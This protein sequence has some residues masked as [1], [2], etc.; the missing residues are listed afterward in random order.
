MR[1]LVNGR[2]ACVDVITHL[3]EQFG[4]YDGMGHIPRPKVG[5]TFKVEESLEAFPTCDSRVPISLFR[6]CIPKGVFCVESW[7]MHGRYGFMGLRPL[8]EGKKIIVCLGP[9]GSRSM[10]D[11]R[12]V[13][14]IEVVQMPTF[15]VRDDVGT[16]PPP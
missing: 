12:G 5:T 2:N 9:E 13:E 4:D 3:R 1:R 14:L 16:V 8:D 10:I 15:S 11:W 7:E 6:A